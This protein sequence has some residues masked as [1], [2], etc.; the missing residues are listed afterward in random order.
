MGA[1]PGQGQVASSNGVNASLSPG[2]QEEFVHD[3]RDKVSDHAGV[4][5]DY[6]FTYSEYIRSGT[7]DAMVDAVVKDLARNKR[8]VGLARRVLRG[9][10]DRGSQDMAKKSKASVS[11]SIVRGAEARRPGMA[12][13]VCLY[14]FS[15]CPLH[16]T[17][18]DADIDSKNTNCQE[19]S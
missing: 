4:P 10:V 7:W 14:I 9:V 15:A 3:L 16:L 5:R 17:I 8:P 2:K 1:G 6:P 18:S 11:V 13:L 19:M 12:P